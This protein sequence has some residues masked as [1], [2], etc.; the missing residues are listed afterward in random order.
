[1]KAEEALQHFECKV[2]VAETLGGFVTILQRDS[3][4]TSK[5]SFDV[6][7]V[8]RLGSEQFNRLE[9]ATIGSYDDLDIAV[10]IA[11]VRYGVCDKEWRPVPI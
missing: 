8:P 10:T 5:K 9:A 2:I 6:Q 7:F 4:S 1:M 11:A 3:E